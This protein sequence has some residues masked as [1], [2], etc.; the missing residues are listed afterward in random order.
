MNY[1]EHD[2]NDTLLNELLA[3]IDGDHTAAWVGSS[4][5]QVEADNRRSRSE[6]PFPHL[7]GQALALENVPAGQPHTFLD[8][9]GTE[10]IPVSDAVGDVGGET[11]NL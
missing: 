9:G 8:V 5:A 1:S 2:L 6:P 3:P 4:S 11:R 10:H 7:V